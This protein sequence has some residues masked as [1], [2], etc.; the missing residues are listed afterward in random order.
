MQA[1][2]EELKLD[3]PNEVE[4]IRVDSMILMEVWSLSSKCGEC[5][6]EVICRVGTTVEEA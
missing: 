1:Y 3:S 5:C 2:K 6:I 4:C